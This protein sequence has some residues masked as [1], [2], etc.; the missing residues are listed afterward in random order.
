MREDERTERLLRILAGVLPGEDLTLDFPLREQGLE[1][2]ALTRVWF[3]LRK[4]FGVDI[5]LSWLRRCPTPAALLARVTEHG[6]GDQAPGHTLA[7]PGPDDPQDRHAPFPLTDLQQAYL[8]AK[9]DLAAD[10]VGCHVYREFEVEDLDV[11][12]LETAWRK[13]VAH[14]DMLRAAVTADGRQRI[15]TEAEPPAVVVGPRGEA[16]A[17]RERLS[18]HRYEPGAWPLYTVEVSHAPGGR[19][20]VHLSIDAL[21]VDG[22]GLGVLLED[23]W[24]CYHDPGHEL[25]LPPVTVRE[26]VRQ[27]DAE[28]RTPAHRARLDY[29]ADR[30]TGLAPGPALCRPA[31]DHPRRVP[32]TGCVDRRQWETIGRLAASWEVSPTALVLTLFAENFGRQRDARPLSLVLTTSSRSRLPA[33]ADDVVGPFTSSLVLPLP[34]TLDRPLRAAA[35]EV[36]QRLWEGLDHSAVSGVSALRALRAKE[37]SA[38]AVELPVVFTS[39]LGS[40]RPGDDGFAGAV[41]YAVSQTTGVALDHQMWERDGALHLRW[42]VAAERFAPGEAEVLF[43]GFLNALHALGDEPVARRRLN[44]LQQAYF[45]PRAAGEPGPWD[46][47][48]VHHSFEVDDLDVP[49]LTR[50]WLRLVRAYDV[51]RTVV[52]HDGALAVGDHVPSAWAVPVIDLSTCPEPEAFLS[53]LSARMAGRAHPLGRGP[54]SELCVTV[55][56]GPATVHLTTDLTI[57]DGRSIHFLV[58][59]LFRLYADPDAVVRPSEGPDAYVAEQDRRRRLPGHAE[60]TAHWRQ[61]IA[62]L[63]PGPPVL[64]AGDQRARQRFAGELT[65]WNTVKKRAEQ[66]GLSPD[67]LLAAAYTQALA[68]HCP[69]PFS[70]PVVRWTEESAPYRPGEYTALS[71]VTRTDA[72]LGLWEQAAVFRGILDEDR[73]ADGASGLAELRRRVMRERRERAFDLPVVYTGRLDVSGQQLPAGVR[74][75]PWLTCTPDVALDCIALDEGDLL[76]FY[77]DATPAQFPPGRLDA[78]FTRYRAL[79]ESLTAGPEQWNATETGFPADRQVQR[80]FEE[81]A[82]LR[83]D[84]VAVRWSH[85]GT[86][87][88][89][90]L[91]RWANRIAWALRELGVGPGTPVGISVRRG[92]AMVAAVYGVLK[93][94]GCYV[95]LEPSLPAARA[96][97][98]LS[99]A[100]IALIVSDAGDGPDA[101]RPV[102]AGV[103]VVPVDAQGR[104]EHDPA[105]LGSVD[106]TAYV[107]F[108]SGSTGKPKGVAVSHRPLLNLLNWCVRTHGFGPGDVGL[109]VTSLGFD[110]S[111]FDVLGLLGHGA[112]LYVAD[113]TEQR[114][115]HLLLEVLLNEPITFWNSA[116]TTLNQLAPLFPGRLGQA[117]TDTLRLV[118]LS[119]DFTPLPLPDEIRRLFPQA[120]VVS[121]GGATEATVWSNWFEIG[122]VDPAWRSIPYGRPIDN[123]RYYILDQ[124]LHPC[125]TG[126]EGDLYIGG[127]CLSQGYYRQPALT[128]ERFVRDPFVDRPGARMYRTGDRASFFPDGVICFHGR[129]DSQVK[130]RGFRV[131][132]G[133]IEHHVRTAPG[134]KDVVALAQSD[135]SGDRKVVAYVVPD[136]SEPP[137]VAELRRH[138]AAR[139]PEYMVPNVVAFVDTFPATSNGKLDRGALP[140]PVEPGSRHLLGS[141]PAGPGQPSPATTGSDGGDPVAAPAHPA[142]PAC[143][144]GDAAVAVASDPDA[145]GLT[146]EIAEIFAELLGVASV[147]PT[148]DIWDLGT[149]SFTMVQVSGVLRERHGWRVPVSALLTDPTIAGI[150]RSVAAATDRP[151]APEPEPSRAAVTGGTEPERPGPADTTA[152]LRTTADVTGAP[153][154]EPAAG[155]APAGPPADGGPGPLDF[156]SAEE[157]AE[158][159]KSRWDLR[160]P[161]DGAPVVLLDEE[162]VADEHFRWR[163]TR[164][165]FGPG[166]VPAAAFGS[167]LGL[168]RET[169]VDGRVRRLYPSAGDTYSV[170]A[171][172]HVRPGGVEGVPEGLYYYHP[173]E[174][175]LHLV[176]AHPELARSRHFPYNRPVFD[177]AAFE[178]YL[179]GAVDAIEPLYGGDSESFQLLE[180]G[181]IG[182]LLLLAQPS[183]GVGLCPIGTLTLDGVRVQL[184]LAERHRYLHAFLGGTLAGT[185]AAVSARGERPLFA[186]PPA[187]APAVP[188]RIGPAAGGAEIAIVG[189]AGR[190]PGADDLDTF[191]QNLSRGARSLI[192]V[193][194]QRRA[195]FPAHAPAGGYLCDVDSF[196]SLLFRIAPAEAAGLDPQ[197]R[198]LLHTVWDCMDSAGHTPR[199]LSAAGRVGVFCGAMWWDHQHVG[200]D[201]AR[202]GHA[203]TISATASEAAN[204]IS[205]FFGFDGPSLA[206]D[207]SCS[208]SLTALHLA[209]ESLRRGE[210]DSALVV[211]AN[212][213]THPYHT[214]L[215]AD[216]GLLAERVPDGAFDARTAGWSPG[217]GVAGVLLRPLSQAVRDGDTAHAVIEATGIGHA[218]GAGRFGTPQADRL[219][220]SIDRTLATAGLTPGDV[221]YVECAAAGALLAD[222]SELEALGTVF[223][224]ETVL[225]GTVKPNIGHLEAAAGLSQLV[226]VLMQFRHGRIAPTLLA[227]PAHRDVAWPRSLRPAEHLVFWPGD[228]PGR[229]LVNA[230]GATG[231]YGHAVLRAWQPA[232]T[233]GSAEPAERDGRTG[234]PGRYAFPLTA[235]TDERLAELAG[236]LSRRLGTRP[237]PALGDIAFTLQSGR[238]HLGCRAVLEA[239]SPDELRSALDALAEGGAPPALEDAAL[240]AWRSGA[241]IDWSGYRPAGARRLSLPSLPFAAEPLRLEPTAAAGSAA[242]PPPVRAD[243]SG[244]AHAETEAYLMALYAEVSGIPVER[245]DAHAPLEQ[246]GVSSYQV[247]QLAARLTA[248]LGERIPGT[249]FFAHRTLAAVAGALARTA[250][251]RPPTAPSAAPVPAGQRAE[252]G[253]GREGERI[254]VVGMAGRYPRSEGL[255]AFWQH[256]VDGDDLIS[257]LPGQRRLPGL[258][259]G[260]MTGGFLDDVAGFDPLF[261][262][263]TPRDAAVLDPQERLFLQT[264]WHALED[265]GY[266]RSRLRE[267]HGGR[268]G[269]FVGS[270]YNEYP[271]FGLGGPR[272][273]GSAI[274]GIANRVSYF[275]DL[276]G[277]SLTVDTMC[278][279]SLTA[280]HLAVAALRRGECEAALVGGVNL[281]LHPNKF[282]TLRAL[283]MASSDHRCRSFGADGDG[284]VPGEGVGAVLLKP[285]ARAVADGDRI[286]AVVLGTAVNHDG[287]TNGY[288]VPNP[289]AQ[290]ETIRQALADA[291][292]TPGDI[293]Y[294][295]AH[296][297]GTALGDPI[298]LDGLTRAFSSAEADPGHWP[299]GSVKSGIG[300]L[301]AAAGMA[302]LTKVV[303]QFRHDTLVPS[304]HAERLNPHIDWDRSPFRVQREATPW[305]TDLPR[306][307]GISSFGAGGTNAHIVV[308]APPSLPARQAPGGP[309][310][311]VI[312]ARTEERLL[313]LVE[314]WLRLLRQRPA[315]LADLAHTSRVGREALRERLATVVAGPEELTRNLE[316]FLAG[317]LSAVHRGSAEQARGP[318]VDPLQPLDRIAAQ[319][320]AG[321]RVDWARVHPEPG[322]IA[323]LPGYPF[324]A[325]RCWADDPAGS[326]AGA[327]PVG[328]VAETDGPDA[329][330]VLLA[331]EWRDEPFGTAAAGQGASGTV[332]CLVADERPGLDA[333]FAP[334]RLVV[335][336]QGVDF[337]D[338][339]TA[340][341]AVRTLLKGSTVDGVLDLCALAEESGDECDAGPWNARLAILQ[342]V[343][344]ARPAAGVRILQ[345]TSGL[346]GLPGAHP[347]PAGARLAGFVRVLGAEYPWAR[348]TV[349]DT[350]DPGD[351]PH[352]VAAW[353]DTAPYGE[354]RIRAGVRQR[355]CLVPAPAGQARWRPDPERVYLVTGGTRGLGALAARHLVDR[356]ARRIAVLGL[357]SL[358][359][360]HEWASED[361]PGPV[362]EAVAAIQELE[363][364]G[365]RVMHHSGPL[366]DRTALAAFLA[367]VRTALG[368]IGGVVHCAG[369]SSTGPAAFV[370]KELA[371]VRRVLAPKGDGLDALLDLTRHDPLEFTLLFS[372]VSAAAPVLAAGVTDYAAANAYLD[373]VA[374]HRPGVRAVNWPVW[375]DSGGATGQPDAAA[376]IG[377]RALPDGAGLAV[378]DRVLGGP[379]ASVLL[380][381]QGAD[382]GFDAEAAL[383]IPQPAAQARPAVGRAPAGSAVRPGAADEACPKDATPPAW[384]VTVVA[385]ALGIPEPELE[386]DVTFGDLGV[387]SVLLAELVTR[388]EART[389]RPLEPTVLLD[390]PT[391]RRLGAHLSR[392]SVAPADAPAAQAAPVG[393]VGPAAS[394][395]SVPAAAAAPAAP[396]RRIAVIGMACRFPGAPD[397]VAFWQLLRTGGFAV[398]EVPPGRW[399]VDRLYRPEHQAGHSISKWGGFVDA[400][401][402]FDPEFFGMSDREARDLDPAIR[403]T[404]EGTASCLRDAGYSDG[405]LRG[406]DV[407]V[408]M[409]ARMSGYRRRIGLTAAAGGLG[410]DQ[411]FI[412]ARVAH[413][414]DFRGPALVVDSACSSALVSVQTAVRSL[415]AGESRLALAGGVEVLL[416]EEPYLEFS[417]ARALS[418]KGRCASFD[419]DAD[420]FV[421]GE[422]CGV[423]LLKPLGRALADGDR[424]HAVLEA[425]AVGN[426]GHTM[427]LTTPNP[428]AQARVVRRALADAGV[429][430]QDVGLLEAHGTGTMIG[431]PMEL[432]ALTEVFREHTHGTGFCALGSVKSNLG[433]L[434][435]AAGIAGLIKVLLAVEHAEIPPTLFCDT[436]NPRFDFAG[437]PFVPATSLRAWTGVRRIAGVSAFGLGGTN[438]HAVVSQPPANRPRRT[439]L[440]APAFHRRR[441]WWDRQDADLPEPVRT[442]AGGPQPPRPAPD[443][444]GRDRSGDERPAAEPLIA[445]TL[446][447]T[448]RARDKADA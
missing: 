152:G 316:G 117:G 414:Y 167:L 394:A 38:A 213:L 253:R 3:Q 301:E 50:A 194:E 212:L 386:H 147:E 129:A 19:S 307:A 442:E 67:D 393:L 160:R 294:L 264:A 210:C 232:E 336:R 341:T 77:W 297:T 347:R 105:P 350:D 351:L 360:R 13:V 124:D 35:T 250:G 433:H 61:R 95:P 319:W 443:T 131:E 86:L 31:G 333:A 364:R 389:G 73:T 172:L 269:V 377:L 42:D 109:C 40:G 223:E 137:Q 76:R 139:L 203:A 12:A 211:A 101:R 34:N 154:A 340:V 97:A 110:L 238:T 99:D 145:A 142:D 193:P 378:L 342:Q 141:G 188:G 208:S 408:F 445:S 14:H 404:L 358:P 136:G 69:V 177:G 126:V 362:A 320:A 111:V 409:G 89:D 192:D 20:V 134:V 26:C 279:S 243:G 78:M 6:A 83:P 271:F 387:E 96:E 56:H 321:G 121:L 326:A 384:L 128:A 255:D 289:V 375:R 240:T 260:A 352:L 24:R 4:E 318:E 422:G 322:R 235:Q 15:V 310:T 263:I 418:P 8:V 371:D 102:P 365:A 311:V 328:V 419:K 123:A 420:G 217:E 222:A 181:Y 58:R 425:V 176:T 112:S 28:Q 22:H 201:R 355:P 293:G 198:L 426:D 241:D 74:L 268:V 413:Q 397:L 98:I 435:S 306:R 399:D 23:W 87:T 9:G 290:A 417:V 252:A 344:A 242:P 132:L 374:W 174:H 256:L 184:G 423:L 291:G 62:A 27:L 45:V 215:L 230:V 46:G 421:P 259:Q 107:I 436:P 18:H 324:A 285:L 148:A 225:V 21:I 440:P 47:C 16:G 309:Q 11:A 29:W 37:R 199:S 118:Y 165:E 398:T 337:T 237:V 144:P 51:L 300:H 68:E 262:G 368:P 270:M 202:D 353:H 143:T 441:L 90:G 54:H 348:S 116:P 228:G 434:L 385:E 162:G 224:G 334:A 120:R 207:T 312:S 113:E 286:H 94:G 381:V 133:E 206:V 221:D 175:A 122:R 63:H 305:P 357:R 346:F 236:L 32:L 166:P 189:A 52:T 81:Q 395:S 48:Q 383:R 204:R 140:W 405:E 49:R 298:E 416:D 92:P 84:A 249:L 257:E 178:L 41:T 43:A 158:F 60:H 138:A 220:D 258:E 119:G 75:G 265:A 325:Q 190:F 127:E 372:S 382:S 218:G 380:P 187:A 288:T 64:P 234:R 169:E 313:R 304:L 437:S 156:F 163:A 93:A 239:S 327:L 135:P 439:A 227:D 130:I 205:H 429:S 303:L 363:R 57:L 273:T 254:A 280:V 226:K 104:P 314:A 282:A 106:D 171:Y 168:L 200:V 411:N 125:D 335:L 339:P 274:A 349:V 266:S 30:L 338:V 317:D 33:Q 332:L 55:G 153:A 103:T 379:A 219:A 323:D 278:S 44:D 244:A 391:L 66:A 183:T 438:A 412:A 186:A 370:H 196:D 345:V 331:R 302:G 295:E 59:E 276:N 431:D 428:V 267:R 159:K 182:Q 72:G 231:T 261:F 373:L 216:L 1:S 146:V 392:S 403:L 161:A 329:D 283:H 292:V 448:F 25:V 246:Y 108:T 214:R 2:L 330:V 407:G 180:A 209:V 287:K 275:L 410:G 447:L 5:P 233:G 281:S 10:P 251:S 245:L 150:A 114:D 100:E 88:F 390:H 195:H 343:L 315:P 400:L 79:L 284:F 191:W 367:E 197:L 427:G 179:F 91:N 17:V 149:T 402:D 53:D 308:E 170:Q 247:A 164:R 406:A 446:T 444:P 354:M 415:L 396:D 401:E 430:A 432:R 65:G 155:T 36:H 115:P 185:P 82:E 39:L 356:G 157:R 248:D 361:L 70:L 376:R 296:G 229:A 388:I 299:I 359:P 272:P 277:P 71:W 369:R 151:G 80:L 424:V 366:D 7:A 85:G 173:V